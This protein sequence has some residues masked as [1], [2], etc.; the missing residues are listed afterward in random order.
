[1]SLKTIGFYSHHHR[2]G[3]RHFLDRGMSRGG[4]IRMAAGATG[5]AL[6]SGFWMPTLAHAQLGGADPKPIPGSDPMLPIPLHLFL[7]GPGKEPSTITDFDGLVGIT[8]VEGTGKGTDTRTGQTRDLLFTADMRFLKG[9]Y[10][11]VD[12]QQRSGTF[13]FI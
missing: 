5:L 6:S 2:L 8:E 12:G 13:A 1:M 11:G 10:V 9:N 7:P 4:F 3:H